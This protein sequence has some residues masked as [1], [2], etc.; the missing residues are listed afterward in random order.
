MTEP[1]PIQS[2]ST[3]NLQQL[4]SL[5]SAM[6]L[7][8]VMRRLKSTPV[9]KGLKLNHFLHRHSLGTGITLWCQWGL[10][11]LQRF[12]S[13]KCSNTFSQNDGGHPYCSLSLSLLKDLDECINNCILI[14]CSNISTSRWRQRFY[15]LL[16]D[17]KLC[18]PFH[19]DPSLCHMQE[20]PIWTHLKFIHIL[21]RGQIL[22]SLHKVALKARSVPWSDSRHSRTNIV[23]TQQMSGGRWGNRHAL[24]HIAIEYNPLWSHSPWVQTV[25]KYIQDEVIWKEKFTTPYRHKEANHKFSNISYFLYSLLFNSRSLTTV[26]MIPNIHL[27]EKKL[28][29]THTSCVQM[30]YYHYNKKKK[31]CSRHNTKKLSTLHVRSV[32][33]TNLLSNSDTKQGYF[34]S[35]IGPKNV[36]FL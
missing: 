20:K 11:A 7:R 34:Q 18:F 16:K 6:N 32:I 29:I 4:V 15:T 21:E 9:Q 5:P 19:H 10:I 1:Y 24:C 17:K 30:L 12:A 3:K 2:Y 31:P 27:N 28:H 8:V 23:L 25:Y 35:Q 26:K 14:H 33:I 36:L 13:M 22:H